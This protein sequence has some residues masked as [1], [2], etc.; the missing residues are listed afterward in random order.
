MPRLVNL[1][2]AI[3]RVPRCGRSRCGGEASSVLP[4]ASWVTAA[5]PATAAESSAVPP[6]GAWRNR[7]G[8]NALKTRPREHE[9]V[10]IR[11]RESHHCASVFRVDSFLLGPPPPR[12]GHGVGHVGPRYRVSRCA[13]RRLLAIFFQEK[14]PLEASDDKDH[15]VDFPMWLKIG[16]SSRNRTCLQ[17][18]SKRGA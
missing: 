9:Q 4:V 3:P 13:S 6:P 18:L 10:V 2:G 14:S 11:R 8:S 5:A 15:S 7:Q 17:L 16:T 12:C 1:V